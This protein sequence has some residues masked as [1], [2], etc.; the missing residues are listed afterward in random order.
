MA[1]EVSFLD[2]PSMIFMTGQYGT[3]TLSIANELLHAQLDGNIVMEII[4]H[5]LDILTKSQETGSVCYYA[6]GFNDVTRHLQ[7]Y[8]FRRRTMKEFAPWSS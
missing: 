5:G 8:F 3:V 1:F 6:V 2:R 4:R 7:L